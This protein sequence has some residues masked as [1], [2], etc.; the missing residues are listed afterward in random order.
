MSEK[1]LSNS[2][3]DTY[4]AGLNDQAFQ[5][6]S[7]KSK[8]QD[9]QRI[10]NGKIVRIDPKCVI[11]DV[12]LKEEGSIPL[13][14]FKE[15]GQMTN[16]KIGDIVTVYRESSHD[17]HSTTFSRS[18][19]LKEMA[20]ANLEQ[21]YQG[22]QSLNGLVSDVI[23]GGFIVEILNAP[24]FLPEKQLEAPVSNPKLLLGKTIKV[25]IIKLE[26]KKAIITLSQKHVGEND[27]QS[28]NETVNAQIMEVFADKAIL[29]NKG[30]QYTM[31]AKD[32]LWEKIADLTSHLQVGQNLTVKPTHTSEGVRYVSH[33][34]LVSDPWFDSIVQ[35]GLHAGSS[36]H[37]KVTKV[38]DGVAYFKL[39]TSPPVDGM[40]TGTAVEVGS[41]HV[42]VVKEIDKKSMKVILDLA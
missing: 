32:Y 9:N 28:S 10:M 3:I 37:A 34:V 11:V 31:L 4:L 35:A 18:R 24:A 13:S 21:A 1:Q 14:E 16:I 39:E 2:L 8:N 5:E 41:T 22:K 23:G 38:E 40:Y 33:K 27:D 19:A 26:K 36:V 25:K 30:Q 17:G 20:W 12:G 7:K 6:M 15:K 42:V 29:G